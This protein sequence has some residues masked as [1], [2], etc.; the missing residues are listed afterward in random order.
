MLH[1]SMRHMLRHDLQADRR[2]SELGSVNR[3]DTVALTAWLQHRPRLKL[4]RSANRQ[5]ATAVLADG[6]CT[7]KLLWVCD[8]CRYV[9]VEPP[10]ISCI[11][12]CSVV[13]MCML[14]SSSFPVRA[15]FEPSSNAVAPVSV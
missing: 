8:D 9:C 15:C 3:G 10:A 5:V 4:M 2:L 7:A 13:H 1:H 6:G 14:Y 11:E 12:C